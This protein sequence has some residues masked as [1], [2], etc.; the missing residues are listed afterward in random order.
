MGAKHGLYNP[1]SIDGE[2]KRIPNS[3]IIRRCA[4]GIEEK[5]QGL[6]GMGTAC[7]ANSPVAASRS[8]SCGGTSRSHRLAALQSQRTRRGVLEESK[9]HF[10]EVRVRI[11]VDRGDQLY[12]ALASRVR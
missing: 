6:P 9:R 10:V 2:Q 1:R 3:D 5:L 7:R 12:A 8:A 11:L 4:Q